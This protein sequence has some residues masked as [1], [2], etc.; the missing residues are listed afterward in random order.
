MFISEPDTTM[1]DKE[2]RNMR[3]KCPYGYLI[4]L[5]IIMNVCAGTIVAQSP[6]SQEVAFTERN[7]SGLRL[8]FTIVPGQGK[9]RESLDKKGIGEVISQFGWHWEHLLNPSG[10]GPA[11]LTEWIVLVGGVEYG[12]LIPGVTLT[13]GIREPRGFEFGLG[14]NL[15]VGGET[16]MTTALVVAAGKTFD[17]GGAS[18]PLNLA[19]VT[20]PGGIRIEFILGYA[21][22]RLPLS[23]K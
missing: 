23:E 18:I 3:R 1:D 20:S 16:G 6:A 5:A 9:T 19:F 8:G 13:F 15:L 4:V 22:E 11:F 21:I 7:L 17:F 2:D 12:T 14:P 10:G